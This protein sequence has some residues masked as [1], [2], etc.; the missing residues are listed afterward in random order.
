MTGLWSAL[1]GS[2]AS[3]VRGVSMLAVVASLGAGS[4]AFAAGKGLLVVFMPPGT[5]N[6]LAQWQKG[7]RAKAQ[8]LGY[9]IKIIETTRDQAE[10]DSQVQQELASGEKVD[11]YIWWPYVNAAGTGSL[12][13]LSQSGVPVVFT[14]QY[15]IPGTEKF[16]T[17][18][19][20][21][22]DF[23]NA[24]TAA[25]ALSRP[26]RDFRPSSAT[27]ASSSPSR[28]ATPQDQI[29]RRLSRKSSR[30]SYRH[31]TARRLYGARRLQNG[32]ADHSRL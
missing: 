16:W 31:R 1:F 25:K 9:D 27:R 21:V 18:Y 12:R 3:I 4:Q 7:A 30:A 2:R 5:D 24:E 28:Q 15:P 22:N 23:L 17:A 26:A 20:G 6:Y 8:E 13:A 29:A 11:G 32:V 10:Q 19:A 14:N